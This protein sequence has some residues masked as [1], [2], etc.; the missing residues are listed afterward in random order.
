MGR[1][2]GSVGVYT[3]PSTIKGR[4]DGSVEGIH[5]AQHYQGMVVWRP[6]L[7]ETTC[8][9]DRKKVGRRSVGFCVFFHRKTVQT[10]W[11]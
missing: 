1:R 3:E 6:D 11:G 10:G 5:R 2:D 4:R 8:P 9:T 7:D